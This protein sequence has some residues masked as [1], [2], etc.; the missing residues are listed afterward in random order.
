MVPLS[1]LG[2]IIPLDFILHAAHSILHTCMQGLVVLSG[3]PIWKQAA[4]PTW[5]LL[6]AMLGVNWML[7]PRGFPQRWLGLILLLPLFYISPPKLSEGEMR[8][9]VLDVGQ[10]LAVVLQTR[11]HTFLYDAG[12]RFSAQSDAGS[13]IIVPFL[14]GA[15]IQKLD[16]FTVSHDDLDHSGGMASVLAQYP[17]AWLMSSFYP[18]EITVKKSIQC[19]AGQ[20]WIWDQVKFEMLSP[21]LASYENINIKD[22]NRSC[23]VKVSSQFGSLLL[24]GDIEK[25]TE[26]SL[27]N[28]IIEGDA[29]Q[30]NIHEASSDSVF[31]RLKSD[32]VIAPHHGSKTS[33]T[34]AFVQ[35]VGAQ[36]AIFSV[37]YLNRF[38][39]PKSFIEKRFEDGGAVTYRSDYHGAL[40]LNFTQK[41]SISV[42][43]WRHSQPRYW[44]DQY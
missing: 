39:H 18:S 19:F 16:G 5:T 36:Y 28:D 13:R 25:E 33:S 22:N 38:K 8:A 2:S 20:S 37:G 23:V 35:A 42:N 24:T 15:G 32:V 7:L 31:S 14:R 27:L 4:P 43:A 26:N 12:P 6:L 21:T 30:V 41:N 40:I 34:P 11:N 17:V 10:G 9:T 3:L 29:S 44:H 1:I